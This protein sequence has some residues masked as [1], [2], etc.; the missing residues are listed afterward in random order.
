VAQ[1]FLLALGSSVFP[2][3]LAGAAVILS[4]D[5]PARLLL[6]FW[7]GGLIT[8][9][10]SGLAILAV[11]GEH[12]AALD[13]SSKS[14][15][16]GNL[17]L[18]GIAAMVLGFLVGTKRGRALIDGWRR[19]RKHSR[20]SEKPK[21][22]K[23]PWSERMLGNGSVGVAFVA[24][25]ILNLPGPFY[26]IALG[27]IGQGHYSPLAELGLVIFFNVIMLLMVEVPMVGYLFN[28]EATDRRV[29]Q[30][31]AWLNRNGMRIIG[32]IATLWGASLLAKGLHDILG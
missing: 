8:S 9:I 32:T 12:A 16:P 23:A 19:R 21:S 31:A 29:G 11:F 25:A 20:K 10:G 2:A 24:G 5:K 15:S 17:V 7:I 27:D 13:H 14:L 30:F 22:D 18:A 4:R 6:A 26:L 28:P 1:I 3:L